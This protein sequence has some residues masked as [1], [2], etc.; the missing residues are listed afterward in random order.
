LKR[1]DWLERRLTNFRDWSQV[2][3]N[4]GNVN[5]KRKP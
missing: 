1:L 4:G 2:S 5:G 3:A